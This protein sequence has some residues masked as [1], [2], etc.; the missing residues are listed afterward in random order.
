MALLDSILSENAGAVDQIAARLGLP[1]DVAQQ[2][3]GAL[4]PALARGIE[5]NT[6]KPGGLESLLGALGSGNHEK[7]VDEPSTLAEPASIEDGN[8]ILGHIFG[9]KDVSRNVAGAASLKTGIDA[10]ILKQIL[11]MLAPIIM[12]ALSKKLGAG[13]GAKSGS[14]GGGGGGLGG[15]GGLLG[16]LMGSAGA[17]RANLAGGSGANPMDALQSFGGLGALTQFLDADKDGDSTDELLDLA[18]KFF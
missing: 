4:T 12:G 18:K 16:G 7:Y 3:V 2:A 15:L 1:P 9:T 6:Q 5:R 13:G 14:G 11:P 10:N 17:G 8:A